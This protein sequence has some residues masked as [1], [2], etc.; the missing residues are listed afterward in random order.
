MTKK[1][2]CYPRVEIR[3]SAQSSLPAGDADPWCATAGSHIHWIGVFDIGQLV[4]PSAISRP[5]S[6]ARHTPIGRP[7]MEGR[8][9]CGRA[10]P[11]RLVRTGVVVVVGAWWVLVKVWGKGGGGKRPSISMCHRP[12]TLTSR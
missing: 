7:R 4:G 1:I 11:N 3:S 10:W 12:P 5:G 8:L 6:P 2:S 9:I